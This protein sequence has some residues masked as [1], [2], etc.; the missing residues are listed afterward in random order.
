MDTQDERHDDNR[1]GGAHGVHPR[2]VY[3]FRSLEDSDEWR[4]ASVT[5]VPYR[6]RDEGTRKG[7]AENE[8]EGQAAHSPGASVD[9]GVARSH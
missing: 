5:L 2:G 6:E 8:A 3:R 4:P 9:L 1:D 7:D